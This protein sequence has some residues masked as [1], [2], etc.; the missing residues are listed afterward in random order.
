M[1]KGGF[2]SPG[3]GVDV[4]DV[5]VLHEAVDE[6]CDA[7]GAWKHR[8]PLPKRQVGRDHDRPR[9]VPPTDDVVEQIGRAVVARQVPDLVELCG[10][11]H[12]WTHV[13]HLLM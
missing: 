11:A 6:R 3:L 10:A 2:L 1:L 4:D 9:F 7:G 12:D 8:S 5:A 13:E